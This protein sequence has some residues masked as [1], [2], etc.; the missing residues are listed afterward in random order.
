MNVGKSLD[1]AGNKALYESAKSCYEEYM[2]ILEFMNK[3]GINEEMRTEELNEM[4]NNL[5]E[6]CS[7]LLFCRKEKDFLLWQQQV[8][9]A[10]IRSTKNLKS[11]LQTTTWEKSLIFWQLFHS[12][13]TNKRK[14]RE[15]S[16]GSNQASEKSDKDPSKKNKKHR[17]SSATS[18]KSTNNSQQDGN[19]DDFATPTNTPAM[20]S[21]RDLEKEKKEEEMKKKHE[22]VLQYM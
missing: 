9:A 17:S 18:Q 11:S 7:Q 2:R 10:L 21:P 4:L 13:P 22:A 6:V 14:E 5:L 3:K 20:F 12:L 15:E 19:E 16:A 8:T 1:K